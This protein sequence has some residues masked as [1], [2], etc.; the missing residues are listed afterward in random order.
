MNA[1][2]LN[3]VILGIRETSKNYSVRDWIKI[4]GVFESTAPTPLPTHLS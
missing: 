2:Q 1:F 4:F 3:A